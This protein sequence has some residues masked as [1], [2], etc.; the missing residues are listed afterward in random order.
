MLQYFT[1]TVLE[2]QCSLLIEILLKRDF[3]RLLVYFYIEFENCQSFR[4]G[5]GFRTFYREE[6]DF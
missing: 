3:E 6:E 5:V 2:R 1:T 4:E